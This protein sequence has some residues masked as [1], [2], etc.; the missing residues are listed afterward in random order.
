MVAATPSPW[1]QGSCWL[2]F[3]ATCLQLSRPASTAPKA[4]ASEATRN[5]DMHR[6]SI[7]AAS[8]REP[9][10]ASSK[11]MP[12]C[13]GVSTVSLLAE[14]NGTALVY[15]LRP[16]RRQGDDLFSH[17]RQD[18]PGLPGQLRPLLA[19]AAATGLVQMPLMIALELT[20]E[21]GRLAR[22]LL[23][24]PGR[25]LRCVTGIV[26]TLEYAAFGR[27]LLG[28]YQGRRVGFREAFA[29]GLRPPGHAAGL[30]V[31]S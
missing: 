12:I 17:A 22:R 15:R 28:L 27:V 21:A 25:D 30:R 9:S 2:A 31:S 26:T 29:R 8:R 7:S 20:P 3:S 18:A 11:S 6:K 4:I 19:I 13:S 10:P 16:G 1:V 14:S 5:T 23:G 24:E